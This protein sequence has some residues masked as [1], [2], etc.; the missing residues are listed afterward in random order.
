MPETEQIGSGSPGLGQA[1]ALVYFAKEP[2]PGRVKTR[3][4]PPLTAAE[5]AGLYRGFLQDILRPLPGPRC[6]VYGWGEGELAG[7]RSL[8]PQG[9]ELRR[10]RGGDLWE[11]MLNC[12]TELLAEGHERVLIRNT[13]SPDLPE[14]LIEEAFAA[15]RPGRIVL[16]PDAGGGYYLLA[17]AEA[18]P[19]LFSACQEGGGEVYRR[20]LENAARLGLEVVELEEQPDVDRYED[21]LA[22]WQRRSS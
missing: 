16:G 19:E 3:L 10:Q 21:L 22:L 6:L 7:L 15:C 12:Q 4:C 20:T 11:R 1:S 18:Y 8:L 5:A 14:R 2:V 17:V 13:D 9:M